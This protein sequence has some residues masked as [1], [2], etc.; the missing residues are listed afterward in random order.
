MLHLASKPKGGGEPAQT[1]QQSAGLSHKSFQ[2]SLADE[3]R[4]EEQ[5]VKRLFSRAEV[6]SR[7]SCCTHTVA[8]RKDLKPVRFNKRF[9]RYRLEDIEAVELAGVA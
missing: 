8:R 7:W 2:T 4:L 3:R 6:A 9:L 5:P 1:N